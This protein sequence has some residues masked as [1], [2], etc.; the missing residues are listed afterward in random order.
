MALG[1]KIS[2]LVH[3]GFAK[4]KKKIMMDFYLLS[5]NGEHMEGNVDRC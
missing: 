1:L 2:V 4:K 3:L 5:Q